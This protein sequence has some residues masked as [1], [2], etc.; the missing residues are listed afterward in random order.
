MSNLSTSKKERIA[1]EAVT[2]LANKPKACLKPNIPVDD[3]GISFDGDIDVFKDN[4]ETVESLIGKVPVQ[5]KGTE[6]EKF[7][8]GIRTF[9]MELSHLQNYYNNQGV[10][11]FVVEIDQDG[12]TKIFYKQLLPKELYDILRVYGN[13]KG[14][15]QRVLRLRPISETNLRS[16]C[17]KFLSETKKQS[18]MLIEH[19]PFDKKDYNKFLFTS[20]TYDPTA[21]V[22]NNIFEHDFTLYGVKGKLPVPLEHAQITSLKS[23]MIEKIIIDEKPYEFSIEITDTKTE[24]VIFVEGS[25]EIIYT[26]A[27]AN[28]NFKLKRL[29]SLSIQLKVLPMILDLLSGQSINFQNLELEFTLTV[30]EE[31]LELKSRFMELH[32]T[33]LK[34]REVFKLLEVREDIEFG[35][36]HDDINVS[37]NQIC[38]FTKMMLEDDFSSFK[39]DSPDQAKLTLF[40]LCEIQLLLFYNPNERP[41]LSNAFSE[42]ILNGH[43]S[44]KIN[45]INLPY[46]PYVLL[47]VSALAHASNLNIEII[48]Q[49]FDR[50]QPY[51][52]ENLASWTNEFCLMCVNAYDLVSNIDLLHLAE[53]IY[54]QYAGENLHSNIVCINQFQIKKRKFDYLTEY[55]KQH[56]FTLKQNNQNN[57]ELQFCV[58]VLLESSQEAQ[59]CFNHLNK[60]LQDYYKTL[61][62][63]KLFT[64]LNSQ[65]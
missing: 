34:L 46:S 21:E 65:D 23:E 39:I 30:S 49:S 14:Q 18:L 2:I 11:L 63:Y 54:N 9:P 7:T 15:K 20:L 24:I 53:H 16:V 36:K 25:L 8:D 42:D 57:M 10:I 22:A 60:D 58:S 55:D 56:L 64:K 19:N 6:V 51:Y 45:D 27:D 3:K 61:P 38:A 35:D 1:V 52:D 4:T 62:I 41:K 43:T 44:V 48:K 31:D 5:V 33:F 28:F 29:H 32:A 40:H 50:I 47:N 37:I 12:E 26:K 59:L 17:M 13:E